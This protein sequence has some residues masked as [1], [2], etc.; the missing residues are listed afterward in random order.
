MFK[1]LA[2]ST[3]CALWATAAFAN[4]AVLQSGGDW[5]QDLTLYLF[6][7]FETSG[8]ST[9]AGAEADVD[10]DLG[11]VLDILNFGASLRYEAWQNDF[12][13][14]VDGNYVDLSANGSGPAGMV[15]AD[16]D[17]RQWWLGLLAGYRASS[18]VLAN[19]ARYSFD[20][21]GGVRYNSLKQEISLSGGP[22]PGL[23]LGGTETWWE[24][25]I[26]ARYVWEINDRWTGGALVDAGGFGVN[27]S[28]LQWSATL[29][30]D[31]ALSDT[32]AL[33]VGVR[34]YSIDFETERSDGTFA[35][36][37]TQV[38]PFVGYTFRF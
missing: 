21:Q 37:V 5:S 25:V 34:Y 33:K 31:Y 29:G 35:Y 18:G 7:P 20:V 15:V 10:L 24:P 8:T 13:L 30:A 12:G 19:G 27:D 2:G 36:D 22:G 11:D 26:G 1:T 14:I 3:A 17:S 4:S 23:T 28:D 6:T 38:G 32:S 9:V 16:V